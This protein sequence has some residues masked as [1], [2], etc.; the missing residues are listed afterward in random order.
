MADADRPNVLFFFADQHHP[1]WVGMHPDIP[2]RTPNLERL[3]E[4]GVWFENAVCPSPLCGPSRACLA[5]GMEYDDCGMPT[6]GVDPTFDRDDTHYARLRDDA[7]Y[8]VMGCGKTLDKFYE[9]RGPEGKHRI[10]EFGL[11]DGV[12]NRGKWAS[13]G[14][15]DDPRQHVYMRHLDDRGLLDAHMRDFDLRSGTRADHFAATHPTPLPDDAYCDSWLAQNG[16]DLI[17]GAPEDRPWHLEVSFIGPHDPLDVT[18]DMFGWYRDPPVEFPG[19]EPLGPADGFDGRTHTEIRRN[20]AAMVENMDRWVGRYLD[21]LE[22]RD[23]LDDTIVVFSGDHGELLGEH[24]RWKK[25]SPYQGSAGVPLVVAGP[26]VEARGRTAEPASVLDVHATCLDYAGLDTG[27]VD[28]RSLRPFLEGDAD[29]HRE[30]VHSGLGPWRLVFDG[31]WKLITGYDP[32]PV[33]YDLSRGDKH[34]VNEWEAMD[35][36]DRRAAVEER[37]DLLFDLERDPNET[38][39][40]IDDHPDVAADLRAHLPEVRV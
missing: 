37:D 5:S 40:V 19:P 15:V 9:L 36:A 28:S 26:G 8:H 18:H 34:Q 35:E 1:D 17:E 23:E 10:E 7:G 29:G 12:R 25:H 30:V 14:F 31:R 6:H 11:S 2:V 39:N 24:G 21:T 27:G 32:D 22:E 38:T 4:R 13:A 16:I 33:G 20:Y 3:T